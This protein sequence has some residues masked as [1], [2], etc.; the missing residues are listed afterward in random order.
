MVAYAKKILERP[1]GAKTTWHVHEVSYSRNV[2]RAD[3]A[4][5]DLRVPIQAFRVGD[6]G[7]AATPIE[8][9][10]EVGL[11]IKAKPPFKKAFTISIANA[12]FGYMSTIEQHKLGGYE[13]CLGNNRVELGAAPKMITRLLTMMKEMQ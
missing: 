9:L 7:I 11:E 5:Q 10:V 13:T 8:T 2:I 4:P 12:A 1:T 6:L 3:E